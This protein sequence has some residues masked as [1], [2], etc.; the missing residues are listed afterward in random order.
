M[1][2]FC[3]LVVRGWDGGL[4]MTEHISPEIHPLGKVSNF[5]VPGLPVLDTWDANENCRLLVP[6][7]T[8]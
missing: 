1:Q 5:Q 7:Q 4:G 2:E 8:C 6:P 3:I